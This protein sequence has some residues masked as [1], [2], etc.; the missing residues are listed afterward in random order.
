MIIL[1][2]FYFLSLSLLTT[3][4][5]GNYGSLCE[6]NVDMCSHDNNPCQNEAQC[7]DGSSGLDVICVCRSG[8]TG[9]LILSPQDG[10]I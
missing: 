1:G 9:P 6:Y 4:F 10:A 5:A 7:I 8:W 3:S 2:L